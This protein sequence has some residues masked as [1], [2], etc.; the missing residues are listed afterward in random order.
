[1]SEYSIGKLT[2]MVKII[3]QIR[4]LKLNT[5]NKISKANA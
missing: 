4:Y 3:T 5:Y 2:I 1:L